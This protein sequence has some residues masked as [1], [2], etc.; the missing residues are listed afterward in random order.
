MNN[1]H[2][3]YKKW[4]PFLLGLCAAIG[5]FG[6]Y[7]LKLAESN[8]IASHKD[9]DPSYFVHQKTQ[10]ALSYI[11]TKYVDSLKNEALSEF[12]ISQLTYAL[13][14]YSEYISA[15]HLQEYMDEMD[16]GYQGIGMEYQLIH[17]KLIVS[18]IISQGP[19]SKTAIA[20]GDEIL[21]INNHVINFQ[22][23]KSDSINAFIKASND[24]ID[25]VWKKQLNAEVTKSKVIRENI[26]T[27]TIGTVFSPY[28]KTI[29]IKI[30]LFGD[31]T[32]REFMEV[33]E[34]YVFEHKCTNLILDLRDNQGGLV[35]IAAD[36]LNQLVQEKDVLLFRT[37]GRQVISKEYKSLGKPF[38][39][40]NKIIVLINEKTASA[41]EIVAGSLQDLNLATI[42]GTPSF[43]KGTILEQF[44][45]ADGAALRIA[46]SRIYLP[47]GR[48]IQKS[49]NQSADSISNWLSPFRSDTNSILISN[50]KKIINGQAIYPDLL[51]SNPVAEPNSSDDVKDI[52]LKLALNNIQSLKNLIGDDVEKIDDKTIDLFLKTKLKDW[53]NSTTKQNHFDWII[54]ESKFAITNLLFGEDMEQRASLNQDEVMLTAL[55]L[56]K[57]NK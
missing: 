36:I 13:D 12:L 14:P 43:G 4:Q 53:E 25:L 56:L 51:V 33:L 22:N 6:G 8:N 18:K 27:S 10:D 20:L 55:N 39:K 26:E 3:D 49:Y 17:D 9:K 32:Y 45:L 38:F 19:I 5:M 30:K 50:G 44:N 40:L 1:E 7:K 34:N 35:H 29:Y 2:L 11:Q 47:S 48:C 31:R 54:E 46:T 37:S 21:S 57:N 15:N 23:S 52:A 28:D 24:T 41:A 42:I 16:G